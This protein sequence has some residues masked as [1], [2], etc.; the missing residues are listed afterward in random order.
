MGPTFS[1]TPTRFFAIKMTHKIQC[2]L[3]CALVNVLSQRWMYCN[4]GPLICCDSVRA[5]RL[6]TK[7]TQKVCLES[8]A[9]FHPSAWVRLHYRCGSSYINVIVFLRP[10]DLQC[11]AWRMLQGR[12]PTSRPPKFIIASKLR[13]VNTDHS[14][15]TPTSSL[16]RG[17]LYPIF[18]LASSHSHPTQWEDSPPGA[19]HWRQ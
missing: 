11:N 19:F 2:F 10:V 7:Y 14:L 17:G 18:K 13:I 5:L 4:I 8:V 9:K 6:Q 12:W 16:L 3:N 15:L 1:V